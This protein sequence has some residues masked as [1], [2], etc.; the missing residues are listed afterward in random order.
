MPIAK[1]IS[2]LFITLLLLTQTLA[3]QSPLPPDNQY[4]VVQDGHITLNGERIRFW[5]CVGQFPGRSHA[6]NEAAVKRLKELG[7]NMIR[8]WRAPE[9]D[10]SYVKGD[11]SRNDLIDHFIY[12]VKKEGMYIWFAGLNQVGNATPQDVTIVNDPRTAAPWSHAVA[13]NNGQGVSI[14]NHPARIWDDR[15][16]LLGIERMKAI[17]SHYNQHTGLRYAD[18]PVMAVWEL[19]NEE[20]WFGR[21]ASRIDRVDPFFKE[22]LVRQWNAFLARKYRNNRELSRAWLGLLPGESLRKKNI[23]LLPLMQSTDVDIQRKA[24]GVAIEDGTGQKLG[25]NDFNRQRGEDVVEFMLEIWINHKQA[26]HDALKTWG[27][28]AALSPLVW[29]TG[30]GHEIQSQYLHQ[31]ADAVS[32]CTYLTGFHHDPMHE[33]FPWYSRLEAPPSTSWKDPWLEQNRIE[34]KPFFVY[35]TQIHNPAK[36]RVEFPMQMAALGSFQDYDI[37]IWHYWGFVPDH[38]DETAYHK[39]MDY[40]RGGVGHPE[41]LHFIYDEVQ[42]SVMTAASALFRNFQLTPATDPTTFV[43]GRKSL[44]NPQALEGNSYAETSRYFIPT[45]YRHGSRMKIDKVLLTDTIIGPVIEKRIYEPNPFQ[46]TENISYNWREGYLMM[47]APGV[48]SFTGFLYDHKEVVHFD[49]DVILSDVTFHNPDGIAY[50]VADD[51]RFVSFTLSSTTPYD[52]ESTEEMVL[53]LVSTSFNKGFELNHDEIR[54]EFGWFFQ[55]NAKATVSVGEAPVQVV[56]VGGTL[57]AD[58]LAGLSY[59]MLDWNLQVIEEGIIEGGKLSISA[60]KPVF[61]TR[62]FR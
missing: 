26:E 54:R 9:G 49:D 25:I 14:R 57:Q 59:Q 46:P 45:T 3:A 51:E 34:G 55:E 23:Q 18:D 41:G 8:Y 11:G 58:F 56:R 4:V 30:I 44:Y 60:E 47:D 12:T 17:A 43:Y 39:R 62:I 5:G 7:F 13:G 38:A 2:S 19:S 22:S 37:I 50:P 6:D 31:R 35:E 27:K 16:H 21:T 1:F 53:S 29:D 36:Y 15:L 28:S 24:L 10:G 61:I 33:R 42:Q 52:L 40:S 48:K 20:W 32:H